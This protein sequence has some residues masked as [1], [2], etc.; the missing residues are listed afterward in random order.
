MMYKNRILNWSS[1]LT[2]VLLWGCS[3]PSVV[4]GIDELDLSAFTSGWGENQ[5]N[6][7]VTGKPLSVAGTEYAKGF[8]T[9]A[10]SEGHI[11]LD[12]KKGRFTASVG[13]D[14]AAGAKGSV[15]FYAFTNK[16]MAFNSG[17]MKKGD[18]AKRIDIN[19]KGITDLYL[20]VDPTTDGSQNDHAD[21]VNAAFTVYTVPVVLKDASEE[22][23]YILTPPPAPEPHI[24][25]A[26]IT[27][28]SPGKPFLF[29]I[30]TTGTR[31][32][33]FT[34]ENL[35]EGLSLNKETGVITGSCSRTG[36][37]MVPLTASNSIG[38]CRDTLE[39]VIGG[40]LALTP[41]MGWNSWYIYQ[42]NV[43]Q[44][45]MEKSAQALY[46]YGLV[47]FGYTF[48][49]IDDGW[50]IRNSSNDPVVGGAV[51]NPDGTIR[52]NK[53]F[54][55]MK[56]MTEYIH[57]L[58][59]K[60]GLYSSPGRTTCGG[61]TA[62]FGY[63]AKDIRTFVDWEF[64][65]L[66]Y[67]W[68]SYGEEAKSGELDELQKPYLLI[69]KL[70]KAAKRDIVLNM[71]QYGMGDVWKWGKKVG[72]NSW[73]TTD[74]LGASTQNLSSNMFSIGFFQEQIKEY[75]GPDGWNDPDYLL[76]G[77]IY[78][79][80]NQKVVLSPYSPS[81]HYT[82]M[83]LWCMMSA[84]LIFSGEITT[85]DDFTRNILCNAEV[86]A[87]DQDKLGKSGYSIQNK[88]LIDIWKK[89]LHDGS[90][91]IAIFNKRPFGCTVDIDWKALGYT[92][93]KSFVRDLWRQKD[94]GEIQ[95]VASFDI[96]RHGCVLLKVNG[97]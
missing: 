43:T 11:R 34:A 81:E 92:T 46:D 93:G 67:D 48:V 55:N 4:V 45:I 14:D 78:D 7:S 37:F 69:S 32:M 19:L 85:L 2:A 73:R 80:K 13:V 70:I 82:C 63:E 74:D 60:A 58:G 5:R 57:R 94:L 95:K 47:N 44:D 30:A 76:F 6:L 40:G 35:P 84:P 96:P 9:H 59:L 41:H 87:V 10:G 27:G 91:A 33:T 71:C 56:A 77:N 29:T 75:T 39:I 83:T 88:D 54:P 50:E 1:L 28:A 79:W 16:G 89:E 62:S 49:N 86:I 21:W 66:K 68:C 64:D 65:F 23:R 22:Q 3:S 31:P 12:G 53:N 25:G 72:G 17:V 38:N 42:L 51:R 97:L 52:T 36:T 26:K 15:V 90:T 24:N 18:A 20:V 61:Y 8:G